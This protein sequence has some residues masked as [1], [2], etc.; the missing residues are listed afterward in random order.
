MPP[1]SALEVLASGLRLG[2]TSFGGPIAHVGYQH[3]EYVVRRRWVDDATFG[4][5]VGLTQTLPG[6]ASSQVGIAVGMLR[7]GYRGALAA[8]IGFTLPSAVLMT[9]VG[10]GIAGT[11]LPGAGPV[12]G[13][14][15]GLK[16]AAV[17]VVAHA[18]LAMARRLTPDALRLGMAAIAGLVTLL[19]PTPL[20]QLG[21]IA[22][23]GM[24]GAVLLTT[25]DRATISAAGLRAAVSRR[26]ALTMAA[27]L[28]V[29]LLGLPLLAAGSG[30][31]VVALADAMYRAGALV[32]GG[33]HVVLPLLE[34]GVVT[35]GY[36][37]ADVFVAGYGAAQA[38]PG[39]LFTFGSYLGAVSMAGPGG[40][41]GAALATVAIFLPGG[42]LVLVAL[43]AWDD[44]RA[45]PRVRRALAGVNAAVVGLLGAALVSPVA[46]SALLGPLEA[47]VA[48][49]G[50]LA[51]VTGRVPP[52]LVVVGCALV[53]TAAGAIGPPAVS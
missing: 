52:L 7:A 15:A 36:V 49:A 16:V 21:L 14:I 26:A 20:V 8:W 53:M 34:A 11:G 24:A 22:A 38:V 3:A 43:A 30:A 31:P 44:L 2:L 23:G 33:G 4:E 39:P 45:R 19:L 28:V 32:F 40:I 18:L 42:L 17:A 12:A 10:L 47:I 25:D 51:L 9:L 27:V 46:T 29:L 6:P 37:D 1:G 48:L 35:P 41:S 5:L 13:L 50:G